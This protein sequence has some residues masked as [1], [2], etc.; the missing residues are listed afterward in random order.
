MLPS[1]EYESFSARSDPRTLKA[2]REYIHRK[3]PTPMLRLYEHRHTRKETSEPIRRLGYKRSQQPRGDML[4]SH[5]RPMRV[6]CCAVVPLTPT[7]PRQHPSSQR[8]SR[9]AAALPW[10]M[11]LKIPRNEALRSVPQPARSTIDF[12]ARTTAS[13]LKSNI[14]TK[15][16]APYI[17]SVHRKTAKKRSIGLNAQ[18]T[19]CGCDAAQGPYGGCVV[20]QRSRTV[21]F[22]GC[23][24][25]P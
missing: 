13:R 3:F 8:C 7:H 10:Y 23:K 17:G 1:S 16:S 25:L 4:P 14:G 6:L 24:S 12:G 22:A 15:C 11:A 18:L 2:L 19:M 20:R 9:R 21:T 5:E